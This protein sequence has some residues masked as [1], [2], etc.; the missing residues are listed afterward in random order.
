LNRLDGKRRVARLLLPLAI[1]FSLLPSSARAQTAGPRPTSPDSTHRVIENAVVDTLPPVEVTDTFDRTLRRSLSSSQGSVTPAQLKALPVYRPGEMLETVPGVL[2]SQHSGEGKANQY[3]LRGFNLDHGTDMALFVAGIPVNMPTHAHGQ[4]YSDLNFLIPELVTGVE[5]RKG[6]YD[7]EE[8]DFAAAGAAHITIANRLDSPLI[9][10]GYDDDGYRR[11]LL[12]GSTRLSGGDLLAGLE[13]FHNDGPW[14]HPDDYR[15]ASG[16][17]RYGRTWSDGGFRLTGMGYDGKWNSTDQVAQRAIDEGIITRYGSLDPTDGGK[18][19]RYSL[20]AEWQGFHPSS[21]TRATAY[22][23]RYGLNLFSNF[24]YALDD[25]VHGDQFEQADSRTVSGLR[26]SHTWR[27]R[28]SDRDV[29]ATAG[30]DTRHD[31][32]GNVGLY[33]TEAQVRLATTRQDRVSQTSVSPYVQ[34]ALQWLPKARVSLGLRSDSYWFDVHSDNPLNSGTASAS[35]LSPKFGLALGPWAHTAYFINAGTGFHSNDARGS[36]ITVDPSTLEPVQKVDPL[37]R[38]TGAEVGLRSAAIPGME[39][40]LSLWG[41]DLASELLFVGDAGT[42]EPSRPSRRLGFEW[43]AG[44]RV[45]EHLRLDA[46]VAYSHARFT[47][48]DPAGDRIPG[49]VEGVAS[50]GVTAHDLGP[51]FAGLHVRYFGPRP[52]IEDNSVRSSP[53]TVLSGLVGTKLAG[54]AAI[55]LE[56]FNLLNAQV[57]DIDYYYTSRL[58]GEP[59]AGV[60]DIHTHPEPPRTFRIRFT[61]SWPENDSR[62][63]DATN[64]GHPRSGAPRP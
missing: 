10:L 32:I 38:A 30:L 41:L 13:I 51:M 63:P 56:G 16:I 43:T 5:Y 48:D 54:W 21:F 62:N 33:D 49:A 64:G 1:A 37:V 34:G 11:A 29:E 20:S 4:G 31:D 2:I 26:A 44:E 17:L 19:H 61:A 59:A 47:D 12:A 46:S 55:S 60:N 23:I 57:S 28:W 3:Y 27:S 35:I 8:G 39:T 58:P 53:S 36:T 24:T 50:A 18:S 52:L 7:A 42:T 25:S 14:V 15:K 22:V 9:Q 45:N 40:S 6:T